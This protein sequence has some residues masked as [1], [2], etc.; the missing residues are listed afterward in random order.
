MGFSVIGGR[1]FGAEVWVL[2]FEDSLVRIC[3]Q[4]F[5]KAITAKN[6]A[7]Y[8]KHLSMQEIY[9]TKTGIQCWHK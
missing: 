3:K 2:G 1:A 9:Q 6:N 7:F 4:T 5:C 8:W